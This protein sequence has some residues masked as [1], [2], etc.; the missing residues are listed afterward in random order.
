MTRQPVSIN[1]TPFYNETDDDEW[2]NS[3]DEYDY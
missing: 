3:R 1:D 2:Y